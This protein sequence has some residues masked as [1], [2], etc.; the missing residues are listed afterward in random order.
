MLQSVYGIHENWISIT[1]SVRNSLC[2]G[3]VKNADN[4]EH[5]NKFHTSNYTYT[6][7]KTHMHKLCTWKCATRQH[8]STL[9]AP[10]HLQGG[11]RLVQVHIENFGNAQDLAWC[12]LLRNRLSQKSTSTDTQTHKLSTHILTRGAWLKTQTPRQAADNRCNIRT[13]Q[14]PLKKAFSVSLKCTS[15]DTHRHTTF[16][17]QGAWLK[18][19]HLDRLLTAD[20]T[21]RQYKTDSRLSLKFTST[22]THGMALTHTL[23]QGAWQQT[24]HFNR[25]LTTDATSR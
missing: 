9:V 25:L 4:N 17:T 16:W 11:K 19:Q 10:F 20:A 18:T 6:L 3:N 8:V 1:Y 15:T 21:S 2:I 13:T 14:D 12:V 22:D 7:E 23:T 5:T 24:Q